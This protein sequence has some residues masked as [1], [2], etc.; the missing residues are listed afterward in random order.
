MNNITEKTRQLVDDW[1]AAKKDVAQHKHQLHLAQLRLQETETEL[2][3]WLIPPDAVTDWFNI[4]F[5]FGSLRAMLASD[6][7]GRV[8]WLRK[9]DLKQIFE[10]DARNGD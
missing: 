9:P 4:W 5:D 8:E 7:T 6:G 2:A 1:T 3:R 10:A